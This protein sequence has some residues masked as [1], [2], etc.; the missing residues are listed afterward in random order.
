MTEYVI[1]QPCIIFLGLGRYIVRL[2]PL[3]HVKSPW[4]DNDRICH[5][6]TLHYIP[7]IRQVYGRI[8]PIRTC[9][10]TQDE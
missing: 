2:C 7:G 6:P 4:L 3:E 5:H 9:Q 8:M 1:I 10:I